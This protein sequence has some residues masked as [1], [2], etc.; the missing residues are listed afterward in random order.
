MG[1]H[2]C[3][4]SA[5]RCHRRIE[6]SRIIKRRCKSHQAFPSLLRSTP[7]IL[8]H[9]IRSSPARN[10]PPPHKPST[11]PLTINFFNNL[12]PAGRLKPENPQQPARAFER[13]SS[14]PLINPIRRSA[15][16]KRIFVASPFPSPAQWRARCRLDRG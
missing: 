10:H 7:P 9:L 5:M 3:Y 1:V 8:K 12:P 4:Q 13:R 2:S 11:P 14:V 6:T 15:S 16:A